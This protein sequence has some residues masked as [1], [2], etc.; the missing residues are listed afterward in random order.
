MEET[1]REFGAKHLGDA[2]R[3]TFARRF[4]DAHAVDLEIL[5]CLFLDTASPRS[6]PAILDKKTLRSLLTEVL[7]IYEAE[8]TGWKRRQPWSQVHCK[9]STGKH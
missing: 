3:I 7:G 5:P 6:S 1:C 8:D 4:L 9:V 2:S